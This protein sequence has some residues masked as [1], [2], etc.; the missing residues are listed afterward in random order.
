MVS[1]LL[2]KPPAESSMKARL[3]KVKRPGNCEALVTPKLNNEVL[4]MLSSGVEQDRRRLGCRRY[5]ARLCITEDNLDKKTKPV[6]AN[7]LIKGLFVVV[8]ILGSAIQ[9]ANQFR[10]EEIKYI[11]PKKFRPMCSSQQP[12]TSH[13]FSS[14]LAK[15]IEDLNETNKL[16]HSLMDKPLFKG[17]SRYGG[18][19]KQQ[20][21]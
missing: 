2:H 20:A 8:G 21:F 3:E 1:K 14:D 17:Q 15:A 9:D 13:L 16:S 4:G 19:G 11:L 12:P 6:D 18:K 10:K 5:R 7:E